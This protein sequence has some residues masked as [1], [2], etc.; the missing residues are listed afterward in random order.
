MDQVE[1]ITSIFLEWLYSSKGLC[2]V[3]DNEFEFRFIELD[4]AKTIVTEFVILSNESR[5]VTK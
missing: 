4:E 3:V 2:L 5:A 1:L